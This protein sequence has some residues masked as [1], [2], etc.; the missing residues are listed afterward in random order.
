MPKAQRNKRGKRPSDYR[1]VGAGYTLVI[2]SLAII[3]LLMSQSGLLAS[4]AGE[5]WA[6]PMTLLGAVSAISGI[7]LWYLSVRKS[8]IDQAARQGVLLTTGIY[9]WVRHPMY[10]AEM[11]V[12]DGAALVSGNLWL[13]ILLPI[14]LLYLMAVLKEEE[15]QLKKQ[16]KD[17]WE[18][19]CARTHRLLILP[20]RRGPRD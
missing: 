20:P 8:G 1:G 16:H 7:F 11:L 14:N 15:D 13:L 12:C 4:G 10:L 17:A 5:A 19:Y 9:G 2:F 3:G 18:D 6:V